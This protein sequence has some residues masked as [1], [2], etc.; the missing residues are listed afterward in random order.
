[1][2]SCFPEAINQS[3]GKVCWGKRSHSGVCLHGFKERGIDESEGRKPKVPR[4][5]QLEFHFK[6]VR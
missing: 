5:L 1:M 4:V 3:F 6:P 2:K